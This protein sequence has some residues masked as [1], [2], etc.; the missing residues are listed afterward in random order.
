MGRR[1]TLAAEGSNRLI[2]RRLDLQVTVQ[3]D[4]KAQNGYVVTGFLLP[5][6]LRECR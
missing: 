4:G 6:Y 1:P 3:G 5:R 2:Q